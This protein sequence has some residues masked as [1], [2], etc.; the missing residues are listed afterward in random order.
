MDHELI[1]QAAERF[2]S[3]FDE[4]VY[5]ALSAF[6]NE[7]KTREFFDKSLKRAQERWVVDHKQEVD[8]AIDDAVRAF[9]KK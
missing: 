7:Q 4:L 9:V 2:K 8:E 3:N 5:Q 6:Q 1:R